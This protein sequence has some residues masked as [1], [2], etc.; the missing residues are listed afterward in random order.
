MGRF[1][2]WRNFAGAVF[3]KEGDFFESQGGLTEEWG[4]GWVAIEAESIEDARAQGQALGDE[5]FRPTW[6]RVLLD[7]LGKDA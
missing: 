5:A 2:V 4:R 1:Y 3:V 6:H 7:G